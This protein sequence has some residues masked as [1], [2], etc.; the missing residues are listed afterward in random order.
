MKQTLRRLIKDRSGV[1]A[2]EYGVLATLL[3]V[4]IVVGTSAV[5]RHLNRTYDAVVEALGG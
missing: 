5:G 4:V 2:I 3:A 1:T